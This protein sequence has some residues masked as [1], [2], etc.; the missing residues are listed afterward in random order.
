MSVFGQLVNWCDYI[1][2]VGSSRQPNPRT[3]RDTVQRLVS[4]NMG[5]HCME[6][7]ALGECLLQRHSANNVQPK[8]LRGT[9]QRLGR[10]NMG[11]TV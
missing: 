1:D 9:V 4:H 6:G 10:H 2:S 11:D 3:P 5:G 8:T 7:R